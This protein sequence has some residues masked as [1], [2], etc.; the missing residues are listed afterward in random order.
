M[1]RNGGRD[2]AKDEVADD[3]VE[4]VLASLTTYSSYLYYVVRSIKSRMMN[5]NCTL[6]FARRERPARDNRRGW[7]NR[8]HCGHQA[9]MVQEKPP[10]ELSWRTTEAVIQGS[11][12][13][14]KT[15]RWSWH[16]W[17]S[18]FVW[19]VYVL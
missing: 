17:L 19:M 5:C 3:R 4:V 9:L 14:K 15:S 18:L 12:W 7:L 11:R 6:H 2:D 1:G 16:R 8:V 10:L 13:Q